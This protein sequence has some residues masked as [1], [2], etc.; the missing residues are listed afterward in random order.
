MET[1]HARGKEESLDRSSRTDDLMLTIEHNVDRLV[2]HSKRNL[3][4]EGV[5]FDYRHR[6]VGCDRHVV[7]FSNEWG[8]EPT[9]EQ[10]PPYLVRCQGNRRQIR[11]I[12]VI[13]KT[14][15]QA[16]DYA[17]DSQRIETFAQVVDEFGL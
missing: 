13:A 2:F 4:S 5:F 7:P 14:T 11:V 3:D 16:T 9:I 17:T 10:K 8:F 1:P 6:F 12:I 15:F